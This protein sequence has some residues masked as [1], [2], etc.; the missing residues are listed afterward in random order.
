MIMNACVESLGLQAGGGRDRD[1]LVRCLA[2]MLI[3]LRDSREL[4]RNSYILAY[5]LSWDERRR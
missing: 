2:G 1:G 4:L 5:F 3:E